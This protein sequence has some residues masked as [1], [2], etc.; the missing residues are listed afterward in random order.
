MCF[1]FDFHEKLTTASYCLHSYLTEDDVLRADNKQ[2]T[3]K[4]FVDLVLDPIVHVCCI[5]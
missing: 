1:R 3:F 2:V 4:L 5:V